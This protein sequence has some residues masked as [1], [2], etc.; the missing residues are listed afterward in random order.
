MKKFTLSLLALI[1]TLFATTTL[2]QEAPEQA[3]NFQINATHTGAISAEHLTPPFKQRWVV[4]F[5]Q[6]I[7][8][9]L[10]ADGKVYVTVRNASAYGTMLYALDGTTGAT[11]WSYALGGTYYWSG[12]CY[13]NGRVFAVNFDG[14]LRAFD[15]ATGTVIWSVQ[16]PGQYSFTA[17][18]TVSQGV[19]Y[20]SGAGSGGT[21]YAVNADSGAVLWTKSVMN[22]DKSSPAVM[23]DGVYV[24]YSCPNVYKLDPATGAQIWHYSPGC[25]GGGGK[26]PALYDGRLYVRDS[27][28][29]IFDANTGSIIGSFNAKNTPAFSGSRGFFLNGPHFFGS[30]GTLEARDVNTN[31][32]LWNFSGDGFLQSAVLVV[33]NYVFVGSAQGKLYAVDAATGQQVWVTTAGTSIPYVDEQNVSQPTTGFAAAEGLLVVPTSTTLVAYEGDT[34][35][36]T[37]TWG[38]RTPAANSAGW[39]NTPVDLPFTTADDLS[40]VESSVPGSPV[41]FTSE[42]ANQTQQVTVTDRAGNS[43][44]FTSPAVN[45]DFTAPSSTAVIPG[46]SQDQE[47]FSGPLQVTLDATDNLSGVK[48]GSYFRLDGGG[49]YLI[50]GAFLISGAGTHT[51]QYASEDRAGNVEAWKTRIINIDP[52]PPVTQAVASGILGTNGWYRSAVQVSLSATDDLNAVV[53]SFYRIDGGVTQTYDGPFGF[54][55]PGVHTI[56]YWSI[57]HVHIEATRTLLVK[58]DTVAPVVTAA[59][60]PSTAPKGPKPVNVTISGSVT[61]GVSGISSASFNVIDEYGT[62]QPSGPV[63]VQANGSYSFTL[64]LPA[65]R[66]GNDRDGHLYTIVV[67]AADQ[68][69]NSASATTTFR[70][71]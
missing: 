18:P 51:L 4:N 19:V 9:P 3:R 50:F 44:T 66:P 39:N 12:I 38:S 34:T 10:I 49:R 14:L 45:I 53:G 5:G 67:S 54:S 60:N 63:T 28:D 70:I 64:A 21:V 8:Y 62:T 37:L 31:S 24:S 6:S 68:A 7:S 59:A 15:G 32:L 35:P 22:G 52:A 33:N 27:S 69:G 65:N 11:V 43:A 40:G 61:D 71:N 25:S 48:P 13:E 17:P 58:I 47:W 20:V 23:S 55:T 46:A 42:G 29:S 16:L 1:C 2:A 36:P 57:D 56:D 30:Y 26:T 41:K